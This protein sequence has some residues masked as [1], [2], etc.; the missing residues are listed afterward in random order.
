MCVWGGGCPKPR[1]H[2]YRAIWA[3]Q[4][5]LFFPCLHLLDQAVAKPDRSSAGAKTKEPLRDAS[6]ALP[7][8]CPQSSFSPG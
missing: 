4:P 8:R 6:V 1:D 2:L 3:P 5:T 7:H